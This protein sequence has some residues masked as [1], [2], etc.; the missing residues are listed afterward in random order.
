M[1]RKNIAA[2]PAEPQ[3]VPAAE[4]STVTEI[5]VA[6]GVDPA[7]EVAPAATAADVPTVVPAA[8]APTMATAELKTASAKVKANMVDAIK[9]TEDFFS[10]GQANVEAFVKCGQIW[11]AGVQDIGKQVAA[12]AQAQ[13]D[14][15]VATFK[16]LTSVKSLKEA[17]DLQSSLARASMEK[18]IAEAGKLTDASL[19]LTEQALAPLTARVTLAVEKFGRPV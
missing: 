5:A 3:P 13:V 18:A 17:F 16:A 12:T 6:A 15:T 7:A 10:F 9:T 1:A 8:S 14:Q 19:K 2:A 4:D 11:S